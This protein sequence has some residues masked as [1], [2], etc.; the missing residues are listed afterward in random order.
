MR[1]KNFETD[2]LARK[3]CAILSLFLVL[4]W[5][6]QTAKAVPEGTRNFGLTTGLQ[7]SGLVR[8]FA[9]RGDV[10][11]MCSSDD[12]YPERRPL[13]NGCLGQRRDC[14]TVY[15]TERFVDDPDAP[16]GLVADHRVNSEILLRPPTPRPCLS[17]S[18]CPGDAQTC[19]DALGFPIRRGRSDAIGTCAAT[20]DIVSEPSE[21]DTPPGPARGFCTAFH[22]PENRIWHAHTVTEDGYWTL[23]FAGETQTLA[24]HTAYGSYEAVPS[25]KFFEVDVVDA[26]GRSLDGGR[27]NSLDWRLTTHHKRFELTARIFP[28]LPN[29]I[30]EAELNGLITGLLRLVANGNGVN[31]R[32]Q[33]HCQWGDG[34]GP[35]CPVFPGALDANVPSAEYPIF[36]NP[37]SIEVTAQASPELSHLSFA[38]ELGTASLSPNGDGRQDTGI[39]TFQSNIDATMEITLDTNG[40]GLFN[41]DDDRVLVKRARPGENQLGWDGLNRRGLPLS[42]GDYAIRARLVATKCICPSQMLT[43]LPAFVSGA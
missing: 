9:R 13:I 25:T 22:R 6:P 34:L 42:T 14:P 26:Q 27:L 23:D 36:L 29:A 1:R 11:H 38:D 19:R 32:R 4:V 3:W 5:V 28:T 39:F 33:S 40:D 16:G 7:D 30:Y 35:L 41:R 8:V 31:G 17:D 12:G 2:R 18:D 24:G 10:I 21:D 37:P 15:P 20:F 43:D